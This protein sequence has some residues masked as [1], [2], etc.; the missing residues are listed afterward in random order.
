MLAGRSVALTLGLAA[1]RASSPS[2][3]PTLPALLPFDPRP[4]VCFQAKAL[5]VGLEFI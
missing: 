2:K 3:P 4:R 1:A 5:G